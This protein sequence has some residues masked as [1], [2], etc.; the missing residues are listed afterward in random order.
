MNSPEGHNG[1]SEEAAFDVI[2]NPHSIRKSVATTVTVEHPERLSDLPI[3]LQH[4]GFRVTQRHDVLANELAA[5]RKW[6]SALQ[7][8]RDELVRE[9]SGVVRQLCDFR[10]P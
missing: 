7:F 2:I 4:K 6:Q 1:Q 10:S 9:R 3:L 8:E 5:G